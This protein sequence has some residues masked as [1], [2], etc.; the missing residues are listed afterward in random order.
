MNFKRSSY[1][2]NELFRLNLIFYVEAFFTKV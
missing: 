2:K 1:K